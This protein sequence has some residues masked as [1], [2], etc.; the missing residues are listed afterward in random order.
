[1]INFWANKKAQTL[2]QLSVQAF[3]KKKLKTL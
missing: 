1:M 2:D 3:E